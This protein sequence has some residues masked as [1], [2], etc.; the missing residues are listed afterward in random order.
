MLIT[1]WLRHLQR[2]SCKRLHTRSVPPVACRVEHLENRTLLTAPH[3]LDLATLDGNNGFQLDGIAVSD[4]SGRSVSTAGDVN[5]DGYDDMI[6]GADSA[7]PG[8]DSKAGE[9]Y[10]VFGSGSGFAASLDLATL[11]GNNGFRLDGIDANDYS[12]YSVSTAGDVNGDGYDDM[13]VGAYYADPGGDSAAGETYVVFGGDFSEAVTHAGTTAADTLTGDGTAN[14]IVAGRGNDTVTGGGGADVI[15]AAE[16]ND[17]ITISDT[18]FARIDGGSGDDTLALDGSGLAL[19]LTS[20]ADSDLLG[21][22]TIDITGS[23]DNTLTLDVLEVLNSSDTSN[24]LTVIGNAGDW[25]NIG[26]G[27]TWHATPSGTQQRFTQGAATLLV[28]AAVDTSEPDKIVIDLDGTN[29]FRIDGYVAGQSSGYSVSSAG[30]VNGDG[31]D[32]VVVG[33][34]HAN[35]G[36]VGIYA[37]ET[38]VVFGAEDGF[39]ASLDLSTLDGSNGFRLDGSAPWDLS[40]FSVSSAGDVNGDAV[41]DILVGAK[42]ASPG[43]V[44]KAGAAF[45]VFGST[46]PFAA[47]IDL[48][49]LDGANGFRLDGIGTDDYSGH[50]VSDAGD[51]NGDGLG[52]FLVG[53]YG[54]SQGGVSNVGATYVVFGSN[55]AFAASL[56]LSMLDGTNGFRID[57]V[58]YGEAGRSVSNAGDVNGDGLGDILVGARSASPDGVVYAGAT[59]VIFGVA[60]GFADSLDLDSLD[61][62]NGFRIDGIDSSDWSGWS[63]STAGD[64]NGDGYADVLVG[65]I[66]ADPGGVSKAGETYVVFGSGS[67]FAASLDLSALDGSNG[68]RLDGIDEDDVSGDSVSAAGDIN[69]DGYDDILIG[70]YAADPAGDSAAGEV[71]FVFGKAAG[72]AASLDL[73]T[74]DGEAGVWLGGVDAADYFGQ[75]V[76]DAGD[77]NGDGF[78]DVVIG[79]Q[80]AGS[81]GESYVVFGRDYSEAV[82]HAGTTAAETLTG[83]GAA[84]VIVAGGGNDLINAGGGADVVYAATGH[85]TVVITDTDFQRLDGGPGRDI[86]VLDGSGLTLDL[87]GI[88]DSDLVGIET[89]DITGS[90]DNTLVLDRLE[91]LNSSGTSNTLSVIGNAGDGVVIVLD[92]DWTRTGT[93]SFSGASFAV[94]AN[95]SALLRLD[96]RL[97]V[98]V[99][100]PGNG[101][102]HVATWADD[103]VTVADI[104]GDNSLVLDMDLWDSNTILGSDVDDHLTVDLANSDFLPIDGLSFAD[105]ADDDDDTIHFQDN[106]GDTYVT[107]H[108]TLTDSDSAVGDRDGW[109]VSISGVEQVVDP[110]S[111]S[112]RAIAVD[113]TVTD[114]ITMTA[115]PAATIGRLDASMGSIHF[116]IAFP[117]ETL[118]LVGGGGDD[119]ITVS[120]P[121]ATLTATLTVDGRDGNDTID[122]TETWRDMVLIGG[123]GHDDLL[124]GDGDDQLIGGD[125]DDDLLGGAGNDNIRGQLGNDSIIAGSGHDTVTGHDGNDTIEGGSGND[126]LDGNAGDDDIYGELGSDT[127][128]GDTGNDSLVGGGGDDVVEGQ[129]DD[130]TVLGGPGDDR[131]TGGDGNDYMESE[132]GDDTFLGGA[133]NDTIHGGADNDELYG[134]AGDDVLYGEQNDDVLFGG[135]GNDTLHS[136]SGNDT[137]NGNAGSDQAVGGGGNVVITVDLSDSAATGSTFE[138]LASGTEVLVRQQGGAELSRGTIDDMSQLVIKGTSNDDTIL[139]DFSSGNPLPSGGLVVDATNGGGTDRL[140]LLGAG[141]T[142]VAHTFANSTTGTITVDDRPI[143]HSGVS[144]LHDTLTTTTRSF[145]VGDGNDVITLGDDSTLADGISRISLSAYSGIIDFSGPTSQLSISTGNGSDTVTISNLDSAVGTASLLVNGQNDPDTLDASGSHIPVK[146]NGSGGDD[147][148]IGGTVN[149]T[150]NG[151]SGADSLSGGNG[152]D[153]LQGQGSSYDTLSGGSGDDTLDGGDGY[154]RI[155]E[156]ADVNFTATDSSLSGLGTDTLINIQLVQL[157]GGSTA[158]VIDASA[159][160]GRAF[161][162]GSGGND[163]L[164]GGG[165][166]DRIFGGSGRDLITGGTSVIDPGPGTYTYDV[167]RGQGGNY[168]TLV[169]GNGNDKLNGGIGHDSLVGGDGDDVLTGEGGNDTIEGGEGTDRLYERGNVN[170]ALTNTSLS[171]GLGSNTVSSIETAYLKGGNGDNLFDTTAFSGDVT[172]IGVGGDDTLRGGAGNDMINGRSGDDLITGG[173]GDDTLQGMRGADVLNGG[174]GNDFLDGGTQD[175]KLSGWT[176]DDQLYGRSENDI[177]VGGNGNDT[178]YG[179]AGNDILQGDDGKADTSH[180]R[181]DDRLDGGDGTDTVRGGDGSDTKLDDVSEIDESFTYW[182]AW[183]DAV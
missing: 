94:L 129:T 87:T 25:V 159:F 42:S 5:G 17:T 71:Y 173:D 22:E 82:T 92:G 83:D 176:G 59:Y 20:I 46:D 67:P 146:L 85:D 77:V 12:G 74:L 177:L 11:D 64:V 103:Q 175:D 73:D 2:R 54:A 166:Y 164:T 136:G 41:D 88:A 147:V 91:V 47:S 169:G 140:E 126:S 80:L 78:D 153:R 50:S 72:W 170:L 152:D 31:F 97:D 145:V 114:A 155:S 13:I 44:S 125:G 68:F 29:G 93:E 84:N 143:D 52:D 33:A 70:A 8:G 131:L 127:I 106:P 24:T 128:T 158:N 1:H 112:V 113:A 101:K 178:L 118:A 40:G 100:L 172:L 55:S 90:G 38:F 14:V 36:G 39:A 124:G 182:D 7:D 117:S 27:W 35:G 32:D 58:T 180:E 19:D 15:Y 144:Q 179:A 99:Q 132:G 108:W 57:G 61:G 165:W 76:S 3:P 49:T 105:A 150:L 10:V 21:I 134:Q 75:S 60:D 81:G 66:R 149:D 79:A 53:A 28:D 104:E 18:T 142:S 115:G 183:V 96:T 122:A 156:S 23:G 9:T 151:G 107:A 121:D 26:S 51:V 123:P 120:E 167:L 4:Y 174:A 168:D 48:D 98:Q 110:S 45:I 135:S 69:G 63:V 16:G 43:G 116:E 102:T 130:D 30:D 65:A 89:I 161:L 157:F 160:S 141:I 34:Y 119:V 6:V 162:N 148:L 86:L 154:D 109:A 138:I 139:V 37:G 56:D 133:G 137:L 171:G 181:D 95:G 163:T 62:D 111:A